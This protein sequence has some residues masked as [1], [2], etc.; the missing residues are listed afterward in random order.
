MWRER[1]RNAIGLP[2]T[3][4]VYSFDD[5]RFFLDRGFFTKT[6][7]EVRLYRILDMSVERTL[8]Q[9]IFGMGTIHLHTSDKTLGDF[10]VKNIRN[11][12]EVKE[13]LSKAVEAMRDK[14]RV[15]SREYMSDS[16]DD[17]D[18]AD[19]DHMFDDDHFDEH[20]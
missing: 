18:F 10:D 13:Q 19:D 12:M 20:H 14:K 17:H 8:W 1:K 9:R 15:V 4:T 16:H 3:F 11:V 2:W 7:D 5:E 6:Q